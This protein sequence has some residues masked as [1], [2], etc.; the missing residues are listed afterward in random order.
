LATTS[1]QFSQATNQLQVATEEAARLRDT[2][3]QLSQD[4]DGKLGGPLLSLS[5][6]SVPSLSGPDSP[7]MVAGARMIRA[8]MVVQLATVKQEQ[9]AAI[10]MV[11]KKEGAIRRS[12]DQLLS[13]Y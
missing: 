7:A 10:L 6:S 4:L 11:I 12:S 3:V 2:N 13:E 8:G 1:R 9:N 5:D